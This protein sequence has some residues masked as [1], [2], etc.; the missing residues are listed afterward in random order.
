MATIVIIRGDGIGPEV[1]EE[2]LKVLQAAARKVNLALEFQEAL[3]G[4]A[5]I[6]ATGDPLPEETLQRC[7]Q[8]DAI[9][10]GAVGGPKWDTL[11]PQKRPEQGILGLRQALQLY[12][13]LRPVRLFPSLLEASPL[14]RE[15]IEGT[16]FIIF[17]EL[18]SGLYY[19]TP[20]GIDKWGEEERAVDTLSYTTSEI[21]RIARL[22]F[23]AAAG[24]RKKV[25]SIDKANVLM[26]SLLWRRVVMQVAQ[27]FPMVTLD[28]MFVDTCAMQLIRNP[29]QFDVIV[30]EN[31]FGDIL[32][33]EAGVIAG[34]IGLLPSASLGG[35]GGLYEPIHGAAPDIVGTGRAN[36]IGTILSAALLLRYSLKQQ[37]AATAIEAAVEQV[38]AQGYRTPEIKQPGTELVGTQGMGDLIARAVETA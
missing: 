28:H 38:L 11:P 24:R 6:D 21:A 26:S 30:T 32:S 19:G 35:A 25:S 31:M 5:A 36:P 27:E 22:A 34:S 18:T 15:V 1:V 7:K 20:R 14:K 4:G 10:L 3:L 16:D 37:Q 8:A 33:D 13:N 9:L 23:Q 29:C 12:A 2:G 17:R